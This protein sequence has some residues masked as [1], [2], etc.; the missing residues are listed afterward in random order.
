[1][2]DDEACAFPYESFQNP[3][4]ILLRLLDEFEQ[5]PSPPQQETSHFL[6]AHVRVELELEVSEEMKVHLEQDP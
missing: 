1:M 4:D 3:T 6:I 5:D 2:M